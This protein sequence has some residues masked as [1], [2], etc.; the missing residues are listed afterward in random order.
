M[1]IITIRSRQQNLSQDNS[2]MIWSVGNLISN[3]Q[4]T[5][6]MKTSA[7][8]LPATVCSNG[9]MARPSTSWS[10]FTRK[11]LSVLFLLM[12]TIFLQAQKTNNGKQKFFK[13]AFS[14]SHGA[15]PFGS[16]SSL[17]YKDF[18][19]GID[20]GYESIFSSKNRAQWFYE[21]RMGY[22]FTNG[23]NTTFHCMEM[24]DLDRKRFRRG[25]ERSN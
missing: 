8:L 1:S 7:T 13:V 10:R 4:N 14:N 11:I 5:N 15:K 22:M 20:I 6:I 25:L 2:I 24:S 18:H 12:L 21:I 17:F 3:H 23:F 16:F 19:P 9:R